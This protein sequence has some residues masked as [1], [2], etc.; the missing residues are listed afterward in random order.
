MPPVLSSSSHSPLHHHLSHFNSSLLSLPPHPSPPLPSPLLLSSPLLSSS[1]FSDLLL[2]SWPTHSSNKT[3]CVC[4][5]V[6]VSLYDLDVNIQKRARCA[7]DKPF[8]SRLWIGWWGELRLISVPLQRWSCQSLSAGSLQ[9]FMG[10][11]Q[12]WKS[13]QYWTQEQLLTTVSLNRLPVIPVNPFPHWRRS[14][15]FVFSVCSDIHA[16]PYICLNREAEEWSILD[17]YSV[18]FWS[19]KQTKVLLYK[20]MWNAMVWLGITSLCV[21][22]CVRFIHGNISPAIVLCVRTTVRQPEHVT[23]LL[24]TLDTPQPRKKG[25]NH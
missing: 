24:C 6:C 16:Q 10:A 23:S 11:E 2:C 7:F 19:V 1:F 9:Q 15:L 13:T 25:L 14:V 3:V 21:C 4:V 8:I 17:M 18:S 5:C 12:S 22:E 20:L